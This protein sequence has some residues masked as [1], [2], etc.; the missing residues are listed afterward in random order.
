MM[1]PITPEV[2]III[3]AY[4]NAD[5]LPDCLSTLSRQTYQSKRV[6]I[7]CDRS[8]S[9]DTET[10]VDEFVRNHDACTSIKCEGV[11]RSRARNLGWQAVSSSI[12]MFADGDDMYEPTYVSKAVHALLAGPEWGG[13]CL[14]GTALV[15]SESVLSR[16][17]EAYGATDVRVSS[18]SPSGPDWAW[19]Y[20]R[21]CVEE[22]KGFDEELTQ[23]EDRDMCKRVKHAGYKIAYVGGVNWYHRKPP[24]IGKFVK[25]ECLGGKRR[26]VYELRRNEYRSIIA[27]MIPVFALALVLA[28]AFFLGVAYSM[29]LL[30]AGL[31]GYGFLFVGR[32]RHTSNSTLD[33]IGFVILAFFGSLAS[34]AGTFYGLI[35]LFLGK[36]GIV[37]VDLGRF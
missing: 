18:D 8:S 20:R 17:F 22:A 31:V 23:A 27:N 12:V 24:T 19:V 7:V 25:K 33:V 11:G 34:S 36:A 28:A 10:V 4:N 15:R 37:R 13:V 29:L 5:A 6:I 1:V 3:I 14:G 2:S 21:E 9:D 32:K 30:L 16:Y 35:L 26:V